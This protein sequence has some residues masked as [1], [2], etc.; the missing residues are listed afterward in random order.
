MLADIPLQV[1]QSELKVTKVLDSYSNQAKRLQQEGLKSKKLK[2]SQGRNQ[3]QSILLTN[4]EQEYK[5]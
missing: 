3:R 5:R 4:W 1:F 2:E